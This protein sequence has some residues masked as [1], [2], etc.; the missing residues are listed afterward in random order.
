MNESAFGRTLGFR[1][2]L[3][4]VIGTII[5][6]GIFMRPAEMAALLGSPWL[7]MN[8]KYKET[9]DGGLAVHIPISLSEC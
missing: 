6:S 9:S 1:T 4:L 5:G 8:H 7:I 3:S 2:V